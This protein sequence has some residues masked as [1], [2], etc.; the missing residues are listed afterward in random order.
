MVR[1]LILLALCS[2]AYASSDVSYGSPSQAASPQNAT[3]LEKR[4]SQY[5]SLTFTGTNGKN[6]YFKETVN[7]PFCVTNIQGC[8]GSK[9]RGFSLNIDGCVIATIWSGS[10][11]SGSN[12]GHTAG[13]WAKD[14]LSSSGQNM[15]SVQLT[16]AV[17]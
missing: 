10:G 5:V 14:P 3:S 13:S 2:L 4:S 17:C 12:L 9:I 11:C 15:N 16:D 7:T 1:K 8:V 6:C